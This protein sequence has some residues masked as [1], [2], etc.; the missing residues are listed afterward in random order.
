MTGNDIG[1]GTRAHRAGNRRFGLGM[2][3]L[4]A[5]AGAIGVSLHLMR[6]GSGPGSIPPLDAIAVAIGFTLVI[7]VGGWWGFRAVDEVEQRYSMIA[8]T[9][10]FF[11]QLAAVMAWTVLWIGGVMTAPS[12]FAI[13]LASAL[14]SVIAYAALRI[15]G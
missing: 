1:E 2:L 14:A 3:I 7:A 9:V 10:G 12:A 13:L 4:I 5:L 8:A 15:R 6:H 11:T